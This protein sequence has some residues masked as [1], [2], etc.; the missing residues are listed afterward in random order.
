MNDYVRW[1]QYLQNFSKVLVQLK[2]AVLLHGE[3][4]LSNLEKLG[5]VRIFELTHELG[6]KVM[7]D[8]AIYQGNTQIQEP[9]AATR[10]AF[11][12]EMIIDGEGWMEMIKDRSLAV[13]AFNEENVIEIID[14]TVSVYYPLFVAFEQK[15]RELINH[16]T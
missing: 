5:L 10:E 2:E 8:F 4:P 9:Q 7:K 15:M 3:R 6:W 11:K 14:K 1:Q 12:N 16:D 13:H